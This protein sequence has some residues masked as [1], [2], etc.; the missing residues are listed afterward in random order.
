MSARW[1]TPPPAPQFPSRTSL[2]ITQVSIRVRSL[3]GRPSASSV[4]SVIFSTISFLRA[5]ESEPSGTVTCTSGI[6]H[7]DFG[8]RLLY[9]T[10]PNKDQFRF[11]TQV[12]W[13]DAK[14]P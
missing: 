1:T 8:S 13:T 6:L 9:A 11:A 12:T 14:D 4:A 2:M 7:L 5:S 10:D 3:L